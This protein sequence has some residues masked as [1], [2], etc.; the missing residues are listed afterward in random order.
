M[1]TYVLCL[2]LLVVWCF[3]MK[4]GD[5]LVTVLLDLLTSNERLHQFLIILIL[6]IFSILTLLLLVFSFYSFISSIFYIKEE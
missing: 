6:I 3:I 4:D 2:N 1:M 5:C